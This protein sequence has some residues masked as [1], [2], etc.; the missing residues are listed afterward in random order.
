M[1]I[2]IVFPRTQTALTYWTVGE[3]LGAT[4]NFGGQRWHDPIG[5]EIDLAI[6]VTGPVGGG[7]PN[8]APIRAALRAGLNVFIVTGSDVTISPDDLGSWR[9]GRVYFFHTGRAVAG[10]GFIPF[11][12]L[13]TAILRLQSG[14]S[15]DGLGA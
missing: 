8:L 9:K 14:S 10:D 13:G 5:D 12:D 3:V 2:Q 1:K 15:L 11:S 6:F 4:A 7:Q